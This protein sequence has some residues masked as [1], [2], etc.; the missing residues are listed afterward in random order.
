VVVLS[1]ICSAQSMPHTLHI[2]ATADSHED[3]SS[4]E[5]I[6]PLSSD[7]ELMLKDLESSGLAQI[8]R[9]TRDSSRDDDVTT[10]RAAS[11][12][13]PVV[14]MH[15]M[16]DFAENPMGMVPLREAISKHLDNAYVV[17]I[18]LGDNFVSDML[19]SFV[20]VM[21]R[22]VDIFAEKV[23]AD[24]NLRDGF[25][26]IGYSQGCL[27]I[28]GYIEKYNSPP[29]KNFISVHGPMQG[30]A[31]FPQCNYSSSICKMF[32]NFLG[33]AAY[34]SLSQSVLAQANYFRDPLRASEYLA[35]NVWLPLVNNERSPN[36]TYATNLASLEKLVCV[37]ALQDTMIWPNDSE[38]W[39]FYQDG[40]DTTLL[41][42][43]DTPLYQQDLFGLRTLVESGRYFNISTPGNHL[44]FDLDWL[45]GVLD[46]YFK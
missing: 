31:G 18:A 21:S 2:R 38:W 13:L 26:A 7:A 17:N 32:D 10:P 28:R 41:S 19:G 46:T 37:K 44:Q 23:R 15:G 1:L 22:E 33:M 6:P 20:E 3:I 4:S 25:N 40:S 8:V 11:S 39:G 36:A 12:Y 27:T 34:E 29:V 5:D 9:F 14:Q 24:E 35:G 30:V 16:G 43:Q 45:T 42:M